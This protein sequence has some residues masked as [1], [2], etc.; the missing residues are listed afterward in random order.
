MAEHGFDGIRRDGIRSLGTWRYR[1]LVVRRR[2]PG[3]YIM[4]FKKAQ[5]V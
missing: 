2:A 5:E 4:E 1:D 3:V